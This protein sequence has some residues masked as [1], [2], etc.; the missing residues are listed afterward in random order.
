MVAVTGRGQFMTC[1]T[2]GEILENSES[3]WRFGKDLGRIH[4]SPDMKNT[5]DI[6][7]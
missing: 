4:D 3:L 6:T 1:W 2:I 5:E 7:V